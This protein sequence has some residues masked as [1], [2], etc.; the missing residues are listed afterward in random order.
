M[1]LLF[2]ALNKV[3]NIVSGSRVH[4]KSLPPNRWER[5][6][7]SWHSFSLRSIQLV[8]AELNYYKIGSGRGNAWWNGTAVWI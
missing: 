2:L 8:T 1:C 5:L 3:V 6:T 7:Q 4:R